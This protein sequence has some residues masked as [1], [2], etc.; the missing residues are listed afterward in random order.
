[1]AQKRQ[2]SIQDRLN[3]WYEANPTHPRILYSQLKKWATT[4]VDYSIEGVKKGTKIMVRGESI[5]WPLLSVIYDEV[6]KRGGLPDIEIIPPD[7]N[8]G[9]LWGAAMAQNGSDEQIQEMFAWMRSRFYETDGYIEV[10]GTQCPGMLENWPVDRGQAIDKINQSLIDTRLGKKW[11]LTLYPTPADAANEK[12]G[13]DE[14]SEFV[15]GASTSDHS[16]MA[17]MMEPLERVMKKAKSVRI[18]TR[19]WNGRELTLTMDI[20]FKVI[21][22][23]GKRNFPDGEVYNSPDA[24]SVSGAIFVD[25][26]IVHKGVRI[27]GIYLKFKGGVIVDFSAEEGGEQ[28]AAIINTDDGSHRLGEV[29]FGM[30]NG[31]D[32]VLTHPLYVEKVA[33]TLHI[34]IG[35]SYKD[36][37]DPADLAEAQK[38][39]AYNESA[40]HV[41]IVADARPGGCVKQV[42][43]IDD[44]GE[45]ELKVGGDMLWTIA[46]A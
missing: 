32:R 30:N 36:A 24:N 7:H 43:L 19:S 18:L 44:D 13:L 39:G 25:L 31:L 4:M 2:L 35:S 15:V 12:M 33:G 21:I 10:M 45:Q 11:V 27:K 8:R 23:D 17:K 42:F 14:Y 1:M 28:L 16:L 41:D 22:C 20:P 37:L 34:A 29:A 40:V 6:V 9:R 38:S 26:P 46:E 5:T 3:L